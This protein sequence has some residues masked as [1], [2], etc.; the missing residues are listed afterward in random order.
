M[1]WTPQTQLLH[2]SASYGIAAPLHPEEVKM[3]K[4]YL[5]NATNKLT[6]GAWQM[7]GIHSLC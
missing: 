6:A 4:K 7:V 3:I 5:L 1:A 2:P